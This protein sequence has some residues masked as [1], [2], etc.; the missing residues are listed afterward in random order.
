MVIFSL[1]ALRARN[2]VGTSVHTP[3]QP[4][5]PNPT[6]SLARNEHGIL[7]QNLRVPFSTSLRHRWRRL[8]EWYSRIRKTRTSNQSCLVHTRDWGSRVD[9]EDEQGL[10]SENVSNHPFQCYASIL[11][12][13]G[14]RSRFYY[15]RLIIDTG[16]QDWISFECVQQLGREDEIQPITQQFEPLG[17][18]ISSRGTIKVEW[19]TTMLCNCEGGGAWYRDRVVSRADF[20]VIDIPPDYSADYPQM[21]LGADTSVEMGLQSP[22]NPNRTL[23]HDSGR[24]AVL[25]PEKPTPASGRYLFSA[26]MATKPVL[27]LSLPELHQS[28]ARAAYEKEKSKLES[29]QLALAPRS[30]SLAMGHTTSEGKKKERKDNKEEGSKKLGLLDSIFTSRKASAKTPQA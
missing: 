10:N 23:S 14:S 9:I 30:E 19:Q 4:L 27:T 29:Q 20:H 12:S 2:A 13:A 8:R 6:E 26:C 11:C 25:L 16:G 24:I 17:G 28:L 7:R 5:L 3:Q 21:S 15:P 1:S 22:I 18:R